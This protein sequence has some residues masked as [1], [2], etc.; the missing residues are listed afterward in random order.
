MKKKLLVLGVLT[1]AFLASC[2]PAAPKQYRFN[3]EC[4]NC[5][6]NLES[7]LSIDVDENEYVTLKLLP[8]EGYL[9]PTDVKIT[10]GNQVL[11]KNVDYIY[12]VNENR[13]SGEVTVKATKAL[14]I[15]V[16]AD[17]QGYLYIGNNKIGKSGD[18][19]TLDYM[20]YIGK[21]E[22]GNIVY[23]FESNT[24]YLNQATLVAEKIGL[25]EFKANIDDEEVVLKGMIGWT[26]GGTLNIKMSNDNYFVCDTEDEEDSI[27]VCPSEGGVLNIEGSSAVTFADADVSIIM[28]MR[29]KTEINSVYFESSDLSDYGIYSKELE[30]NN[31]DINL[32][33]GLAVMSGSVGIYAN[34]ATVKD[35]YCRIEGFDCGAIVTVLNLIDTCMDVKGLDTGLYIDW[36]NAYGHRTDSG[37][38]TVISAYGEGFG[39]STY[40][41]MHFSGCDVRATCD[42]GYAI[43]TV[44]TTINLI[45]SS[46]TAYANVGE[47]V[48]AFMLNFVNSNVEAEVGEGVAIRTSIHGA[49]DIGREFE[50]VMKFI[51]SNIYAKGDVAICGF[52][53]LEEQDCTDVPKHLEALVDER[54]E[55]YLWSFVADSETELKYEGAID[56][57]TGQPFF[58]PTNGLSV[59]E[60]HAANL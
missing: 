51:N 20:H 40:D 33:N 3:V 29:G 37:Y 48:H 53:H 22:K 1:G 25:H 6:V 41:V 34:N 30:I 23:D 16:E 8:K 39:I 50:P 59:V 42:E 31:S 46:L 17:E 21:K 14:D 24:L 18:Y 55:L 12:T 7:S 52:G 15:N 28:N 43:T 44:D 9:L 13:L 58:S 56:P 2:S 32:F 47:A 36:L 5:S 27:F 54:H 35:S 57:A 10:S 38:S 26:G 4:T 45:D 19:S 49:Q 60:I 11:I